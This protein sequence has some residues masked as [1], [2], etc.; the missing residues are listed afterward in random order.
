MRIRRLV[1]GVVVAALTLALGGC[2]VFTVDPTATAPPLGPVTIR[3]E[4]CGSDASA[5]FTRG[6][7]NSDVFNFDANGNSN[8]DFDEVVTGGSARLELLLGYRVPAGSAAPASFRGGPLVF[9][10]SESYGAELQRLAPAPA[11]FRWFGY[12]SNI[13]AYDPRDAGQV[14]RVTAEA[15]FGLPRNPDGTPFRGPFRYRAVVGARANLSDSSGPVS[16][17]DDL[18]ELCVDAPSPTRT[19]TNLSVPTSDLGIAPGPEVTARP[20][21]TVTLPFTARYAGKAPANL[22]VSA[23]TGLPGATATP[24]V[25]SL[26][27][28][29]D[30]TNPV[31]VT[32]QVPR[33]AQPGRYPVTLRA[34]LG[35]RSRT[36]IGTIVVPQPPS[37]PPPPPPPAPPS[38]PPPLVRITSPIHRLF[39]VR[40]NLT[41]VLSL[42]VR[43]VP[44]GGRVQVLCEGRGCPFPSRSFTGRKVNPG[45]HFRKRL[46][47][48][49]TLEVRIT[50]PGAIG[51]V[52]RFKTRRRKVPREIRLCLPPGEERAQRRC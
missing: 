44:R 43:K 39:E 50:A 37:P 3:T 14:T 29:A 47:K 41:R 13:F 28:A 32:V 15:A 23:G 40:G 21:G 49:A 11:G 34:A 8:L 26:S 7:R 19:A 45:R 16:C 35:G 4:I 12:I 24:S 2:V 17:G 22:A 9:T 5:P 18:F 25:G 27:P 20:G 52:L 48:G 36:G 33:N 51:R 46:R 31:Q 6:C 10:R 38:P 42:R 30:S 1:M